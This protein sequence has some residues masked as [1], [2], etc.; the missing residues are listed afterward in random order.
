MVL[1]PF[2]ETKEPVLSE[3]KEPRR[4]GPKQK[5]SQKFEQQ[6][7]WIRAQKVGMIL[8]TLKG[9]YDE[10]TTSSEALTCV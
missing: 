7:K 6:D 9:A 2:A 4:A 10:E 1:A 5:W 3:P 8:P